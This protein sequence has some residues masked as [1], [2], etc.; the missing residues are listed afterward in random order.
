MLEWIRDH[1]LLNKQLL[2]KLTG[3]EVAFQAVQGENAVLRQWNDELKL[4][5]SK[6]EEV[7]FKKFGLIDS[8]SEPL[9]NTK[10]VQKV[11]T[12]RTAKSKLEDLHHIQHWKDK[13]AKEVEEGKLDTNGH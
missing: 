5:V 4:K 2:N 3:A 11:E 7:I 6:Y 13:E 10:P 12:W 8:S 9:S 1:F